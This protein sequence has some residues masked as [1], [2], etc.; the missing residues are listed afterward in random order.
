MSCIQFWK[1]FT[2]IYFMC[3][4]FCNYMSVNHI[5]RVPVEVRQEA[6]ELELE[7]TVG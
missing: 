3:M 1:Y 4:D 2:Y 5:Y 7:V 6:L